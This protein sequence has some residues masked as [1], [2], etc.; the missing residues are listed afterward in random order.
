MTHRLRSAL[1]AAIVL[2]AA[3]CATYPVNPR[4]SQYNPKT[5][6]RYENLKG[7]ENSESLFVI[8]LRR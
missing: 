5:G 6:Y 2:I 8:L 1:A 7:P 3:G 4:L